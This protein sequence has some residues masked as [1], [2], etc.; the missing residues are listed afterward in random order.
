MGPVV[1]DQQLELKGDEEVVG[2]FTGGD[3]LAG[4]TRLFKL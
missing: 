1:V 3:T 2:F 4:R